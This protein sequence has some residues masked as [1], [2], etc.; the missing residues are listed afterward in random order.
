[1]KK[2]VAMITTMVMTMI[3]AMI[4]AMPT[5]A[6]V[7]RVRAD[8]CLEDLQIRLANDY[9]LSVA[10]NEWVCTNANDVNWRKVYVSQNG[11]RIAI[12][13]QW[14][15]CRDSWFTLS[16]QQERMSVTG[17]IE[18]LQTQ[19]CAMVTRTGVNAR[20]FGFR[21]VGA[22]PGDRVVIW[23]ASADGSMLSETKMIA[24]DGWHWLPRRKGAARAVI[25]IFRQS[26]GVHSTTINLF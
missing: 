25:T 12:L 16:T 8:E 5:M 13:L 7:A 4:M 23:L 21:I 17:V 26:G 6:S 11:R 15:D 18:Y 10:S 14:D 22:K 1:M 2:L 9:G 20:K 19:M 3:L 24:R